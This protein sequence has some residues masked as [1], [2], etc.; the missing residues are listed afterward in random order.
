MQA[1]PGAQHLPRL[2][3]LPAWLQL[4]AQQ[5]VPEAERLQRMRCCAASQPLPAH[6]KPVCARR[7]ATGT[8]EVCQSDIEVARVRLLSC[9]RCGST[10]HNTCYD[11]ESHDPGSAWLCEPCS[12]GIK[13][14]PAC[15]LCPVVGGAMRLCHDGSWVHAACAVWVPGALV[16]PAG[17]DISQVCQHIDTQ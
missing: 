15:A 6:I 17:P 8:C 2:R 4:P 14:P 1:L 11:A 10:V 5:P 16:T 12:A 9:A 13:D 3:S 7:I